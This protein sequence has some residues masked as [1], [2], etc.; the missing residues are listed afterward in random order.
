MEDNRQYAPAT[1][2][3]RDFI[4]ELL[5]EVLPSVGN[6]LEIASGTG[7]HAVFFA[8]HLQQRTWI[9][10]DQNPL[11]IAS[12]I[13]WKK[14]YPSDNLAEPLTIDVTASD[15]SDHPYIQDKLIKAIVNINM[16]H[17]APWAACLGLMAGAN[18]LLSVGGILY[19]YGPFKQSGQHTSYSNA[20]FDASLRQ[21]NSDWGVRELEEVVEVA[22]S[23]NLTLRQLQPMPANNLS[24]VFQSI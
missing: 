21:Q 5:S 16:I 11:A 2:R 24:V 1:L 17:I 10:S 9:P 8:S 22:S 3:N 13:D 7:E 14:H 19:L 18:K 6:V 20:D 23:H 12:I 4:L 15:W